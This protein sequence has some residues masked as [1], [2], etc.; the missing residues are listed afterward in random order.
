MRQSIDKILK[1][2]LAREITGFFFHNQ[3]SIDTVSGVSA[4]VHE[5]K[6]KVRE[7]LDRLAKAG[8]LEEDSKAATKGYCYTRNKKVMDK[9]RKIMEGNG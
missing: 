6:K 7:T 3:S 9:V 8:I 4:W 5:D 1:N 2:K